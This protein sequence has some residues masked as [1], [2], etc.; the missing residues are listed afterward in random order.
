MDCREDVQGVIEENSELE[1]AC[2]APSQ[3]ELTV[4]VCTVIRQGSKEA[5]ALRRIVRYSKQ[6]KRPKISVKEWPGTEGV[7]KL[8]IYSFRCE[9]TCGPVLC[10]CKQGASLKESLAGSC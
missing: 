7:Y 5:G 1:G 6:N 10:L 2:K 8:H 3:A 9:V 4:A